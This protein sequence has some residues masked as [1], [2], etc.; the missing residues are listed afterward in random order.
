MG[1]VVLFNY[2]YTITVPSWLNE[3][4]QSVSVNRSIWSATI[5]SSLIYVSFGIMAAAAFKTVQ[6]D[7]LTL[8]ASN[9]SRQ[10]TRVC[11]AI[12]AVAIIG[13]GVPVFSVIIRKALVSNETCTPGWALFWYVRNTVSI[14]S[15]VI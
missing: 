5:F 9:Q 3:K 4:R 7:I 11:A 8:L 10:V 1:G 13:L 2:T 6:A 12:F 15:K 14:I